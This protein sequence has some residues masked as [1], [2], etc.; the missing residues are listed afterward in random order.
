MIETLTVIAMLVATDPVAEP[1]RPF[2]L[3]NYYYM[4]LHQ[5]ADSHI[6]HERW[7]RMRWKELC[8]GGGR[9]EAMGEAYDM[10]RPNPCSGAKEWKR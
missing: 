1:T 5:H 2:F 9:Y 8:K 7:L 6:N 4:M 3:V 10:G